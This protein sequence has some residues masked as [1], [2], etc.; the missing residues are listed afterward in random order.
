MFTTLAIAGA[1]IAASAAAVISAS[2]IARRIA[3]PFLDDEERSHIAIS[4][5][6]HVRGGWTGR[7]ALNSPVMG[8]TAYLEPRVGTESPSSRRIIRS[9]RAVATLTSTA[10]AKSSIRGAAPRSCACATSRDIRARRRAGP[11]GIS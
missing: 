4:G 9:R 11:A 7:L 8:R 6:S 3:H 2:V 5:S 10:S 1:T